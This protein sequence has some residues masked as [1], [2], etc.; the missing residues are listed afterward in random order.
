MS[1][2][3]RKW[4]EHHAGT[5]ATAERVLYFLGSNAG[6]HLSPFWWHHILP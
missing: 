3:G 1:W 6:V 2:P 4:I 5:S